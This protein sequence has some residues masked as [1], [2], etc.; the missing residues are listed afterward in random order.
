[1]GASDPNRELITGAY[2]EVELIEFDGDPPAGLQ[3]DAF[4][5]GYMGWDDDPA[6][7]RRDRRPV[8][9]ALGHRDRQRAGRGVRRSHRHV[10]T[11]RGRG[12][13]LGMGAGRDPR[14]GEA[15][16]GDVPLRTAEVL[17]L[18]DPDAR[19]R[20]GEHARHR[21]PR[22]HRHRDRERALPFGMHVQALRRTDT[23]SPI[24]GVEIV[25]ARRARRR[26]R[27]RRARR[28]RDRAHEPSHRRGRAHEDEAR[29]APREHRARRAR[30]SG[31]AAR[32]ARR[33]PRR[34]ARRSTPSTPSRCRPGTG[35][36]RIRRCG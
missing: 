8:G 36:T 35:C 27:P 7:A 12:S 21:R 33:R 2:P 23:P 30:R 26:C 11:R 17:E 19:R 16:A 32:R 20:G 9:A 4:F 13:D 25:R 3:A 31:R 5:G 29:R 18:P 34:D 1:M 22:W 15:L 28:T 24:A 14:V 6:L 10:R